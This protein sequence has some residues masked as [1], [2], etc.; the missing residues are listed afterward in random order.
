VLAIAVVIVVSLAAVAESQGAH[1]AADAESRELLASFVKSVNWYGYNAAM[2]A[3][4]LGS[5]PFVLL[6][7]RQ[8]LVPRLLALLGTLGYA[9]LGFTSMLSILGIDSGVFVTLPVLAFEVSLGLYLV[10]S[11]FRLER[12]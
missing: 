12:A 8:Q 1:T 6:L 3:L 5:L 2:I 7:L 10:L 4:G 9:I 11:G